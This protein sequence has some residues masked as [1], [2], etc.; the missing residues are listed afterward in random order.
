MLYIYNMSRMPKLKT[1]EEV[2]ESKPVPDHKEEDIFVQKKEV[3]IDEINERQ[4]DNT[5][6][7]TIEPVKKTRKKYTKSDKYMSNKK[8]EQLARA[9]KK[10]NAV[11]RQRT[12]D[13]AKEYMEED[14][15]LTEAVNK[16][17]YQSPSVEGDTSQFNIDYDRI[18]DMMIDKFERR[19]KD[20]EERQRIAKQQVEEQERHKREAERQ[21]LEWENKI[22]EDERR[23]IKGRFGAYTQQYNNRAKDTGLNSLMKPR[24]NGGTYGNFW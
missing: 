1:K 16:I 22:R 19:M 8:K 13:K 14:R 21:K 12:I 6:N 23:K 2:Q 15:R 4:E 20:R 18:S 11:R 9:R 17:E 24:G 3:D 7:L 10:S 5:P